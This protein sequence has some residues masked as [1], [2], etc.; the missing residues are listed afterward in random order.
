VKR[1]VTAGTA[2][3]LLL[4]A[5]AAFADAAKGAELFK[6]K[7]AMCHG[8]DGK[9]Q[10]AVGKAM[11]IKDLTSD[12]DVKNM[13]DSE[14]KTVIENGKGKMKGFKGTLSTE[15]IEDIVQHIRSIQK[16]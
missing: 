1:I 14:L 12:E 4:L 3:A 10:T 6:S 5:P 8:P 2:L 13:H 16:K 15:Q 9:G 11:K 7:C